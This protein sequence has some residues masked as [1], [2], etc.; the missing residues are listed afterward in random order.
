MKVFFDHSIFTL[1]KY[2][3]VSNYVVNLVENFS[4]EINPLIISF[5]YKNYKLK[6]SKFSD[7]YVF[8]KK[9]GPLIGLVNK[10]N[11]TYFRYRI[12]TGKPDIIHQTYFNEEK[13][14]STK[15]KLFITEYDL[16]KEKLYKKK[17]ETQINFKKKLFQKSDHI[18]CISHNTKKDLQEEYS[19]DES[20]ISVTH[21]AVNKHQNFREKK[22]NLRPFILYVGFRQRYKNFENAI[23]AY[24]SSRKIKSDFDFVCFG[25]GSFNQKEKDLFNELSIDKSRVHFF[26]GDE[27]DLNYFYHKARLF[28]FP[29]FYEGFGLPLLEAMNMNCPVLCSN[30][31]CF[32][33]IT[34]GAASLFDPSNID[35]INFELEKLIFD[36]QL[37]NDLKKKGQENLKNYSWKKCA[38][39]TEQIYKKII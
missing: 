33:E 7:K 25:G 24:A 39:E 10:I 17:F 16:I 5:F 34:N 29:S 6:E 15:A 30:R 18:I 12:N 4:K 38:N 21:L 8:Y 36:D 14:Y 3:G 35:S 27:L 23:R 31:S 2:G 9:V 13:F 20:K 37:L 26:D 19:I 28:I 32:P 1:Q 22:L 11:R